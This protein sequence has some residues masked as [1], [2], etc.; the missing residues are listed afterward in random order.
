MAYL[1]SKDP[2]QER[3]NELFS[4]EDGELIRRFTVS[5]RA[6]EGDNAGSR[7]THGYITVA[8]DKRRCYAHRVIWIMHNGD[9]PEGMV[10]DHINGEKD[11][12]R[13]E[14]LRCITKRDNHRHRAKL[15][16]NNKS[17]HPNVFWDERNNQWKVSFN[18]QVG[19]FDDLDEAVIASEQAKAA[20]Q[21]LIDQILSGRSI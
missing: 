10:I 6:K 13:L 16:K 14:N 9:I 12:N 17:G 15:N 1:P 7:S 8:I 18:I 2:S 5:S 4:Y 11:D 3:A 21:D 19:R 20:V